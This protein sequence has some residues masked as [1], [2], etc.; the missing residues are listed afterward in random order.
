MK[1]FFY[2]KAYGVVDVD[3]HCIALALI[4][5]QVANFTPLPLSPPGKRPIYLL[6]WRP[7]G[8]HGPSGQHAKKK[9]FD[10]TGNQL[11][12]LCFLFRSHSLYM[13]HYLGSREVKLFSKL[14][15]LSRP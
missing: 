6:D 8:H 14:P 3:L 5:G 2:K 12:P 13:L 10:P 15:T 9:I 1:F 11:H 4:A 7:L